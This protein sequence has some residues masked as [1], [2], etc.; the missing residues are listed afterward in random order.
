MQIPIN[1]W[2]ANIGLAY[3]LGLLIITDYKVTNS[4]FS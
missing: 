2:Y 3:S 1:L 4:D